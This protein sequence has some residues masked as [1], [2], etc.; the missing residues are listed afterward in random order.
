MCLDVHYI[1][2]SADATY[3][4]CACADVCLFYRSKFFVCPYILVFADARYLGCPCADHTASL[5]TPVLV[6]RHARSVQGHPYRDL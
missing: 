6:W 4:R 1:L 3:P 2:V 5:P